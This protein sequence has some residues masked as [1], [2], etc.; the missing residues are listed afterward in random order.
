MK[1]YSFLYL[2]S[3]LFISN[4]I[5]SQTNPLL[6]PPVLNGPVYNL[7]MQ[8]GMH[9]LQD[10]G[11]SAT[12]GY[13]GDILGPTLIMNAGDDV[14]L[15]VTNSIGEETTT[16]WHGLH[17]APEDDGGPH[18]VISPNQ[19]WSPEFTVIGKASTFWYHPHLHHFTMKQVVLGLAGLII[20]RD[21]EEAA[22]NLPRTYAVDDFPLILQTKAMEGD[23]ILYSAPSGIGQTNPNTDSTF[24]VNAT[25]NASLDAPRQV[26]RF[27]I[28]NGA[29]H[30]VFN[31]GISDNSTFWQI[32]SD[33][34]LLNAPVA[35]TR[36]SLAP[37]E[38]AEILVD[39]GTYAVNSDITFKSYA[40]ELPAGF[41]GA[42][43]A[44][45]PPHSIPQSYSGNPLNGVDFDMLTINI[46]N[47]SASPVTSIPSSLVT[48]TPHDA[49]TANLTRQKYFLT[50]GGGPRISPIP[51]GG[52]EYLFDI[53]VINDEIE[54]GQTEIWELHG[55]DRQ[56]HPFHIHDI[57]F[58]IME[59]NGNP[60][61]LNE[62]GLKDVV[63]VRANEVVKIIG[64]FDDFTGETPYMY[65]CH[66]LP[67]EDRGMMGQFVVRQN[68]YVDKKFIGTENGTMSNPFNT[69][70]EGVDVG[71][72]SGMN[73]NI[74]STGIHD[75]APPD[76]LMNK[77]VNLIFHNP[78]VI[79]N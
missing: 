26:N 60:P 11:P 12:M 79:I 40:S 42:E 30:R 25:R 54:V 37:G 41:W 33:G 2:A 46:T 77:K 18:S 65:H 62:R 69:I 14:T 48:V 63:V 43:L 27:R 55:D 3:I 75:E 44:F 52:D 22:L 7:N 17:I 71:V 34:G 21:A 61:P 35:L 64:K 68:V 1:T 72:K 51:D 39:L 58:F 24:F 9:N 32:G 57:Q 23:S 15:N 38:R 36:L 28:L 4:S 13:N 6:I 19:T 8:H 49:A 76:L 47:Q 45:I 5:L 66:I 20:V 53:N 74:L 67:H 70:R 16:H 10:V 73:L 50:D 31:F 56:Y 78:P 59:R 29:T